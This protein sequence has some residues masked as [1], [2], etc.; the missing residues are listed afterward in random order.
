MSKIK[1]PAQ[2]QSCKDKQ[3][4]EVNKPTHFTQ[5][6]GTFNCQMCGAVFKFNV[7]IQKNIDGKRTFGLR[8]FKQEN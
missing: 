3:P 8:Y 2:C 6:W 7:F 1:F 4:I 5:S